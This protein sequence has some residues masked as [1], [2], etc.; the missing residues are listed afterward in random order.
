MSLEH[1]PTSF[2]STRDALHQLAFFAL[3]PARYAEVGRM[4]LRAAPGGFGT[5]LYNGSVAR[6]EGDLLVFEKDGNV[7]SRTI[8]TIRD[9]AH[10]FGVEYQVGWFPDFHDPLAPADPDVS[11]G[12]DRESALALGAWFE[13]GFDMLDRV[14]STGSEDD[15]ASEVQLWPEHFD[16]ALEM[17]DPGRV[18]RASYG[19]SPGDAAHPQPYLYVAPWGEID[20]SDA[21]WNDVSFGG[22]SLG[23]AE[24]LV[25]DD[26]VERAMEFLIGGYDALHAG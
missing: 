10:F 15:D 6:V 11:L 21:F 25:A 8:T 24:L 20:R 13:F 14:G 17:G 12:V 23:Y 26:P 18:R 5:P 2:A 4:G 19:A 16:P 3:S 7:A 1:L 22:A 9:A